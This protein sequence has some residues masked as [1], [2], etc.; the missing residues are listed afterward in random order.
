MGITVYV[1][2]DFEHM[3]DVAAGIVM[4]KINETF[5]KKEEAEAKNI[6]LAP[7]K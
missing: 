5:K 1:T 6:Y 2:R 3:S 4:K 7:S